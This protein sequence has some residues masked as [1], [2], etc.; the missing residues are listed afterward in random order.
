[1]KE[2]IHILFELTKI[3]ITL[4]VTVTTAFG[5]ICAAGNVTAA[6]VAPIAGILSLPG[7]RNRCFDEQ[8]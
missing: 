8:N 4:F 5:Y 2:K 1:M 3:K 6:I 7:T